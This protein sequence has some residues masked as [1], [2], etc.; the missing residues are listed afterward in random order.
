MAFR[1][2]LFL[3]LLFPLSAMSQF[4]GIPA[5]LKLR[6][7]N[8]DTV[9]VIFPVGLD[10]QAK[11]VASIVHQI[12]AKDPAPLGERLKKVNIILQ[13][14][15]TIPNGFVTL[16][17]FYS[18]FFMTPSH[19]NFDFG[20][21]S[22]ATTLG[23]HE[24]RHVQQYNNFRHGLSKVMSYILGEQGLL[25]ATNTAI[26]DWFFEGDAVHQETLLTKQGRGRIPLFMNQYKSLGIAKKDYSWMKLRNGSLK[27]FV[28][29]HYAMGYLFVNYGFK[30]FGKDFWGKVTRDASAFKGLFYPMQKAIKRHSG[31]DYN[32]FR[33]MAL[34]NYRD[35]L[36]DSAME[37]ATEQG[38]ADLTSPTENYV[39]SY[40]YPY[41][42]NEDSILYLKSTYRDIPA[43]YIRDKNGEHKVRVRDISIDQQFGYRNGKIVYAG[44][45]AGAR[46]GWR[47]YSSLR[48]V[49]I[50]TGDQKVLT[51]KSKYFTPDISPDGTKVMAAHYDTD[52][53]SDLRL[54]DANSGELILTIKSGE[55]MLFTEPK[56]ANDSTIVTAVRLFDGRSALA[57]AHINSQIIERL[58][59]LSYNVVG[60]PYVDGDNVYYTA[61]YEGNDDVYRLNLTSKKIYS[62][63]NSSLGNY[64]VSAQ[65]DKVVF[66]T[67]TADGYQLRELDLS[68][69][70]QPE[71]NLS[72]LESTSPSNPVSLEAQAGDIQTNLRTI[73]AP[74]TN[75][76]KRTNLLNFHSWRPYYSDP[77]FTFSIY[78]DN[79][80]NNF[81]TRLYYTY[82]ENENTHGAGVGFVYGG[83]FPMLSLGTDYT[84]DRPVVVNN[85]AT[86]INEW[87]TYAGFSIPLNL[88]KGKTYTNFNVGT[89]YVYTQQLFKGPYKDTFGN[90]NYSYL[91]HF[92]SFSQFSQQAR[93]HILPRFGYA[94]STA[95]RHAIS[96]YD[97]YQFL[98]NG[99]IYLPGFHVKHNFQLTGSFQE[100]DTLNVI[101][102]NRFSNSRGY[103]DYYFSRMWKVGANYHFPLFIP[104]WGFAN[105]FY[106]NRVR[107]NLFYDFTKFYSK[108]KLTTMDQRSTGV[109][110]FFDTKWWNQVPIS[111]GIR[112]SYLFDD[113]PSRL[114]RGTVDLSFIIPMDIIPE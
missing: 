89:N 106:L 4:G 27:D 55:I 74:V 41:R 87:Q 68:K 83:I 7:V 109:E 112:G 62:V 60:N 37:V 40:L 18:S 26:P 31:M 81:S 28:P 30:K 56:F 50:K 80:L 25:V 63:T 43:F 97:S 51:T 77:E 53:K 33:G 44:Y 49:D 17:P 96:R 82:N 70:I 69:S 39:S 59:P 20:T 14:Q 91:H 100:R 19:S 34:I 71:M 92:L 105:I 38:M 95:F 58:T 24:Y 32:E 13:N 21:T 29:N 3:L 93:Q 64:F 57:I 110:I 90:V 22:W 85:S 73:N 52:G 61:S 8:T 75:Y 84:F 101:F 111:F 98:V 114:T 103:E 76:S 5:S 2:C 88:T 46:W 113:E 36:V 108:N 99:A 104:D 102:S 23:I 42:I 15:T 47:D 48:I 16:G 6:Q 107:A 54:L 94:V 86:Y 67:F 1:A 11:Q 45:E 79:V 66:S 9:R 65:G 12:A 10:S 78:G 72:D 35:G